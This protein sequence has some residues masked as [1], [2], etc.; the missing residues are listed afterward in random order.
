MLPH[1]GV[2]NVLNLLLAS[3]GMFMLM[4][5]FLRWIDHSSTLLRGGP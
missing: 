3:A 1:G 2:R 4:L 5:A